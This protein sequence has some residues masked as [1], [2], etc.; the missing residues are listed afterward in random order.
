MDFPDNTTILSA[1]K[2][3]GKTA[4]GFS[5]GVLQS[6][7]ANEHAELNLGNTRRNV[8]VEPLTNYMVARVQQDFDEGNSSL[9]EYL[10]LQTDLLKILNWNI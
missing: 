8:S 10:L 1:A 3:S 2:I 4:N 9:A 6:L 5:I 7:T